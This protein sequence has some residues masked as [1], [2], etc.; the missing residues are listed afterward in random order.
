MRTLITLLF[1]T[2]TA[3]A[4]DPCTEQN[5]SDAGKEPRYE[6]PGPG[7][8]AV[9]PDIPTKPTKGLERGATITP[10]N[11]KYKPFKV[12]YDSVIMSRGKV[13]ELGLKI[14]GLRRLRWLDMHK[15]AEALA[16]ERKFLSS[17]WKAKLELRDSQVASYKKQ[18]VTARQE[19]DAARAWYRRFSTGLIAGI[20]VTA[21]TAVAIAIAAK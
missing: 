19:R 11:K 6:C 15:G 17:T 9:V 18:L 2:S 10:S 8:S 5:Y 13:I 1:L 3:W 21:G 14:K 7:E 16:I 20:V 12:E 4:D